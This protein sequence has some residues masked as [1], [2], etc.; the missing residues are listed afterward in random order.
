MNVYEYVCNTCSR[1]PIALS[2]RLQAIWRVARLPN[3]HPITH[4]PHRHHDPS[5][6]NATTPRLASSIAPS[7]HPMDPECR[8]L[9]LPSRR[10]SHGTKLPARWWMTSQ[11]N[12]SV[13]LAASPLLRDGTCDHSAL[14][15]RTDIGDGVGLAVLP[16]SV[17]GRVCG[18]HARW[19]KRCTGC[20]RS[21]HTRHGVCTLHF[22]YP[23]QALIMFS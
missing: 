12:H 17:V 11:R 15:A 19:L 6:R 16:R 7:C 21:A 4:H 1:V 9:P 10:N 18:A 2:A 13:W 3:A 14:F 23:A 5:Y 22:M 8:P 20:W